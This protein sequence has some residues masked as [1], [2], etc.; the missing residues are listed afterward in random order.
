M[1]KPCTVYGISC[2]AGTEGDCVCR[3]RFSATLRPD[4]AFVDMVRDLRLTRT[5]LGNLVAAL[6]RHDPRGTATE[7]N[8]VQTDMALALREARQVLGFPFDAGGKS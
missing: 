1:T 8:Q 6:T 5:A 7:V 2:D 3:K 4:K